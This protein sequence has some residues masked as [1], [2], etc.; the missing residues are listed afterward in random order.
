MKSLLSQLYSVPMPGTLQYPLRRLNITFN[1]MNQRATAS[2]GGSLCK[3]KGSIKEN[4]LLVAVWGAVIVTGFLALGAIV[5]SI[6]GLFVF[7]RIHSLIVRLSFGYT[8]IHIFRHRKQIMSR[9]GV[10]ISSCRQAE[11]KRLYYN[12]AVKVIS[13]IAFHILL[14]KVSIH[15]A[16]AYTFYHIVQHRHGILSLFKK[17]L[18][19]RNALN[20]SLQLV[21]LIPSTKTALLAA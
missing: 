3:Y 5:G 17:L 14:H 20:R 6:E 7:G 9:F 21:P 19:C 15:L 12:R 8:A 1:P 10:K 4:I 2:H 16:V 11:N 18:F 13:A